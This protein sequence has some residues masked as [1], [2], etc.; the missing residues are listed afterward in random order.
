MNLTRIGKENYKYFSNIIFLDH[1]EVDN[2]V[3]VGVIED[4]RPIAAGV[5]TLERD[6]VRIV[7]LYTVEAYRKRGAAT[8]IVDTFEE[9]AGEVGTDHIEMDF[10]Y[11]DD[12][13]TVFENMGFD[14]FDSD[15]ELL[16]SRRTLL[17]SNRIKRLLN[18]K[19]NRRVKRLDEL[20]PIM[21]K[22]ALPRLNALGISAIP[23]NCDENISGFCYNKKGEFTGALFASRDDEEVYLEL[24]VGN[25]RDVLGPMILTAFFLQRLDELKD[26]KTIHVYPVNDKL[27]NLIE[28]LADGKKIK[29]GVRCG[30]AVRFL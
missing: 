13:R 27:N 3:M 7:S 5:L 4:D 28:F 14:V 25:G 26:V 20:S 30:Y 29:P 1:V 15:G 2:T 12:L 17:S 23:K 19:V 6:C 16:M 9:I 22:E 24:L 11:S 21:K 18:L 10:A 8:L